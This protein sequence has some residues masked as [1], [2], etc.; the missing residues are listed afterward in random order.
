MPLSSPARLDL[1]DLHRLSQ[2]VVQQRGRIRRQREEIEAARRALWERIDRLR[3]A[4]GV[5]AE[6]GCAWIPVPPLVS[7]A[8]DAMD[9]SA[10]IPAA[11]PDDCIAGAPATRAHRD[12][13]GSD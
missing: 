8:G 4:G 12:T 11:G 1:E 5:A 6:A 2:Q 13:A 7:A 9:A 3:E 10:A